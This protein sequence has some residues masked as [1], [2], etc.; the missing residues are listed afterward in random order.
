[1]HKPIIV[2]EKTLDEL[3]LIKEDYRVLKE[4]IEKL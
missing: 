1:M 4:E 3:Y 2:E